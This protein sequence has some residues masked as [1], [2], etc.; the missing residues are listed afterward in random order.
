MAGS[1]KD[2]FNFYKPKEAYWTCPRCKTQNPLGTPF[3]IQCAAQEEQA[4]AQEEKLRLETDNNPLIASLIQTLNYCLQGSQIPSREVASEAAKLGIKIN[5]PQE[6]GL[7]PVRELDR[8][9]DR[10]TNSNRIM[11]TGSG[12]VMGLPGGLLML[13]TIPTD[14]S[15]LTYYS[16]RTI[17]GIG[18]TY[19]SET[20]S[21]EGRAVALLLFAGAT[22]VESITVGGTQV[23][24]STLTK[25]VL[26]KPYRD[27]IIKRVVRE[28][29]KDLGLGIAQRGA[30]RFIPVLGSVIGGTAN[31]LFISNV[32]GRAKA[33]YRAKLV[34]Q[35]QTIPPVNMPPV[36]AKNYSQAEE[37]GEDNP[38]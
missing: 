6:I 30:G 3:C 2:F 8:L 37:L 36:P 1:I 27:L 22:G 12:A 16:L 4:D 35:L 10:F 14:I 18:Q 15:A 32:A 19:G 11:A 17:S 5:A 23:L 28:V 25:N 38:I 7:V 26:T 24:L 21:E 31:Y 29:A 13:A 34:D 20:R 33:H 9:A